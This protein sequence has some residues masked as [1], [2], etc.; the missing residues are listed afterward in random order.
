MNYLKSTVYFI[1]FDIQQN[2]LRCSKQNVTHTS[3]DIEILDTILKVEPFIDS[4]KSINNF[5]RDAVLLADNRQ[6]LHTPVS[7]RK[8][9]HVLS[10]KIL[11]SV[12]HR[13][14]PHGT[15]AG[16]RLATDV[17]RVS[18]PNHHTKRM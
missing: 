16:P 6:L 15:R 4:N 2:A 5:A 12:K 8:L 11:Y 3:A 1:L 14:F 17:T 18:I 10:L 13:E 7:H 9:P